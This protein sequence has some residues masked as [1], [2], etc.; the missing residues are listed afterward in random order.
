MAGE[1]WPAS[2]AQCV[3]VATA[4]FQKEDI[5]PDLVVSGINEGPNYS[6]ASVVS[7]TVGAVQAG[8]NRLL[9][10]V[11][12]PGIAL[13]LANGA[14]DIIAT[15]LSEWC[16][17]LIEYLDIHRDS[18]DNLLPA[19]IGL[20][21]N[22]PRTSHI[23]V[24][25]NRAGQIFDVTSTFQVIFTVNEGPDDTYDHS[26]VVVPTQ[27]DIKYSNN[28]GVNDGYITI[29]P[30]VSDFTVGACDMKNICCKL[31]EIATTK[32][33]IC[34]NTSVLKKNAYATFEKL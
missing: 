25:L 15:E 14:T 4:L 32:C 2:P 11:S 13:S 9:Q 19:G 20:N 33:T 27:P 22:A 12:I 1:K 5:V 7:G 34:K 18:Q 28:T 29:V 24:T 6:T 30:M 26:G 16:V 23:G 21:V 10:N 3:M 8:L 31:D 17:S